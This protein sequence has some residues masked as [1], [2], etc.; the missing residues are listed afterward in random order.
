MNI[1][2]LEMTLIIVTP[3]NFSWNKAP[4]FKKI[5]R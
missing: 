1:I 4:P 3:F 2:K 5:S